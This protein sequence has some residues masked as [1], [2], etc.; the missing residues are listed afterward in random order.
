MIAIEPNAAMREVAQAHPLVEFRDGSA[1]ET[2][3]PDASVDLVTCFQAFSL[4]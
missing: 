2:K 1:E 4:V 3:L